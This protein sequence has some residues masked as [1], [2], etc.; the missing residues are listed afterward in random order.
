VLFRQTFIFTHVRFSYLLKREKYTLPVLPTK[1]R[2]LSLNLPVSDDVFLGFETGDSV[3]LYGDAAS[4]MLFVLCVHCELPFDKGGLDSPV[5]FV[6]GGNSF[7]PYLV[8]EIGRSYG[9]DSRTVLER[10]YVSRAFTAYQLSSLILEELDKILNSKR[11]RLLIVSDIA[12][13][14]F[15]NDIP[16]TEAKNL[17]VKICSKLSEVAAKKRTISVTNYFPSRKSKQSLFFEVVLFSW[18]NILIRLKRNRSVLTL[19]LEDHPRIKPF[20]AHFPKDYNPL[21]AFVKA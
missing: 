21:S 19:I 7:N 18:S 15:D 3:V 12:S 20:S 10:I 16:K 11:A 2:C 8:A 13:L 4:F 17:F 1:N 6:D 14:F 5:V 9:M